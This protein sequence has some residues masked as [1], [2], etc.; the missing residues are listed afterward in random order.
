MKR[1]V[2]YYAKESIPLNKI[3]SGTVHENSSGR[4]RIKTRPACG[5]GYIIEFYPKNSTHWRVLQK[6]EWKN[7]DTISQVR[8]AI[9]RTKK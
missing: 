9:R 7:F 3:K 8:N 1:K 2:P 5:R 6:E 4:F